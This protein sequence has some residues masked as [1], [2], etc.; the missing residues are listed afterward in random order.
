MKIA[1]TS[2]N[3]LDVNK[4]DVPAVITAQ[5]AYLQAQ[6]VDYYM[7]AGDT[8]NDITKTQTYVETLQNKLGQTTQVYFLAGNHDMV[9]GLTY[10][11][12]QADIHPRYLHQKDID[13]PGTNYRVIGNNGWYDFSLAPSFEAKT[14]ADFARWRNAYWIDGGIEGRGNDQVMMQQILNRVHMQLQAAKQAGQ[15]VIFIT[16]FVPRLEYIY[17]SLDR[18]FWNMATA[19]MGSAHLGQLLEA[20]QVAHVFFGHLHQRRLPQTING[21]TYH[22]APVG[23]GLKRMNEW[24]SSDFMQE[25]RETL[26]FL[27]I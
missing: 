26:Q 9:N 14:E 3:H 16:H 25:W 21:V 7:I 15:Q 19:L 27:V 1:V 23:Y 12:L 18:H 4:V 6:H 24:Q 11:Q 22:S 10:P 20:Y 5:A 2:D 13:L 8:F 17:Y